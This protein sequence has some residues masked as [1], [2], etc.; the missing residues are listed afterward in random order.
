MKLG[1]KLHNVLLIILL[2]WAVVSTTLVANYYLMYVNSERV[3]KE[4]REL[5]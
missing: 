3:V 2:A 5:S 1:I 4:L